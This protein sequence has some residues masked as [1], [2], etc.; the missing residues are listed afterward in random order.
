MCFQY[1]FF[2]KVDE[3][4]IR[5]L[6]FEFWCSLNHDGY[7]IIEYK[8][9]FNKRAKRDEYIVTVYFPSVDNWKEYKCYFDSNDEFVVDRY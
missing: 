3:S 7:E 8:R 2:K 9:V 6:L 4:G 1:S 5:N